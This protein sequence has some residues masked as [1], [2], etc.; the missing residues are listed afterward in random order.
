MESHL[1]A[2][3][4]PAEIQRLTGLRAQAVVSVLVEAGV[5]PSRLAGV[6]LGSTQNLEGEAASLND[7]I[8]LQIE[9]KDAPEPAPE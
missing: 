1:P 5:K 6:G 2:K 4:D 8:E 9:R 7:R 3:G